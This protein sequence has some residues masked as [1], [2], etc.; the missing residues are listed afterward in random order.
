MG[1]MT[2]VLQCYCAQTRSWS[3]VTRQREWRHDADTMTSTRCMMSVTSQAPA[4]DNAG[5]LPV[6]H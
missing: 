6:Y 2:V 1:R 5:S 3:T 4:A